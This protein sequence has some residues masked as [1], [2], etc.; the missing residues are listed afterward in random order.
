MVNEKD[1]QFNRMWNEESKPKREKF[2]NLMR[3][4]LDVLHVE[5][6]EDNARAFYNGR[7]TVRQPESLYQVAERREGGFRDRR[8]PPRSRGPRGRR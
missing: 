3:A 7:L 1:I 5:F 4:K 8:G 6:T 2:R